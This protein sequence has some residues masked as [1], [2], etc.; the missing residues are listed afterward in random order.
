[1]ILA[2]LRIALFAYA[3]FQ[4]SSNSS[5]LASTDDDDDDDDVE[6]YYVMEP[7]EHINASAFDDTV[8]DAGG[9]FLSPGVND[10]W[11]FT[12][13]KTADLEGDDA[14]FGDAALRIDYQLLL[15]EE[16]NSAAAN[17]GNVEL[18]WKQLPSGRPHNCHGAT[19]LSL[20]YKVLPNSAPI[21]RLRLVLLESGESNI[22]EVNNDDD[23][24]EE[25]YFDIDITQGRVS[26]SEADWQEVR[27]NL[28]AGDVNGGSNLLQLYN[29]SSSTSSRGSNNGQLDLHRLR[30]WRVELS[31]TAQDESEEANNEIVVFPVSSSGSANGTILLD[32]LAFVGGGDLFGSSFFL[33]TGTWHDAVRNEAWFPDFFQSELSQNESKIVLEDGILSVDYTVEQVEAWG[34]YIALGMAAPN[35]AYYNLTNANFLQ[36]G[37]RVRETAT[38]PGRTHLRVILQDGSD[39]C[40]NCYDWEKW[41]NF[42]FILDENP[43]LGQIQVPL[44][45]SIDAAP[46]AFQLT[47]W[48][49]GSGNRQLDTD[50]IKGLVCEFSLDS[51]GEIG[52]TVSGA[53]DLFDLS[54]LASAKN[55]GDWVHAG[56]AVVESGLHFN[57][58][59]PR[60]NRREFQASQC[61]KTC[62]SDPTC[63][64]ALSNGKDCF[65]ASHL[66]AVDLGISNTASLWDHYI[67]FWM[68]DFSKR[69]DFCEICECRE[70]DRTIDC[71]DRDLN[72][73][74]KTFELPW[75]PQ[76][77][78]LRNNPKLVMLGTG[79]LE[80]ISR[81][82]QELWLPREM[83]YVSQ[84]SLDGLTELRAVHI[85]ELSGASHLNVIREPADAFGDVCCSRGKQIDLVLPTDGLTFCKMEVHRPGI[86]S[87]YLPFNI[88]DE[89]PYL[90][91][92]RPSSDFMSEA[93]ESSEKCGEYCSISSECN[94]FTYDARKENAEHVCILQTANGTGPLEVCCEDDHYADE[95]R[96]IP[97]YTAGIPPRTRHTID[98]ARV[99]VSPQNIIADSHNGYKAQ[100]HVSLGSS[101]LRGAVWVEPMIASA[102]DLD[103]TFW[104][105]RVVLYDSNSTATVTVWVSASALKSGYNSINLVVHNKITSCDSAFTELSDGNVANRAT[106]VFIDVVVPEIEADGITPA[107]IAAVTLGAMVVFGLAVFVYFESK[108][109]K[110]DG[111]WMIK[112]EEL[113]FADPPEIVGRGCF[114]T[115]LKTF[116]RYHKLFGSEVD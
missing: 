63:L 112:R 72:I 7:F 108:R 84:G 106:T 24:S 23:S 95:A 28:L 67:A 62:D 58:V 17:G 110:D 82:L 47:G 60:F 3:L 91:I 30:G 80:A 75:N 53:I 77:L 21:N 68:D 46:D 66:E 103:V 87:R 6:I 33:G 93:A 29:S 83:R 114:G 97:G 81:S 41:Y 57:E 26:A 107:G 11:K 51:Q 2:R 31:V 12:V 44:K 10:A 89:A 100:F 48:S 61:E 15:D 101:P 65:T 86:D 96:T 70:S 32:Q 50:H 13:R 98:N 78:D 111:M 69:G 113:C 92:V 4:L 37:Y 18:G 27:V 55:P 99:V 105:P 19:H 45:G 54:A 42:N 5:V 8:E 34:G 88:F 9:W 115:S 104:P 14:L 109:K 40:S 73:I 59:S 35:Q 102:T 52:S 74:P 94:Y 43:V 71:R 16:D 25:Y 20:W 49:G 39:A 85:E 90:S 38:V 36:M 22:S 79:A 116:I 64:Y 56:V 76:L 1:M